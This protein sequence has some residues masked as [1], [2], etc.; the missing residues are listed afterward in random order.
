MLLKSFFR[1]WRFPFFVATLLSVLFF[2]CVVNRA[3]VELDISVSKTTWVKIYWAE[4]GQPFSEKRM[5][6][7]RAR[8]EHNQYSFYLT[9]L[10]KIATLRIDTHQYEGEAVVKRIIIRQKGLQ[11]LYFEGEKEFSLLSPVF[12]VAKSS[13][14]PGGFVVDSTGEDPQFTYQVNLKR[15]SPYYLQAAVCI[16][17]IFLAVFTFFFLTENIRQESAYVPLL[18]AAVCILVMVMA[19]ISDNNSHPDEYV[20][21]KAAKYYTDNW[22]PPAADDPAIRDTYSVYGASRLNNFEVAYFFLGKFVRLLEPFNLS[23]YLKARLFNVML[24]AIMVLSLLRFTELRLLA[25][26][27]LFSPQLW[28]VFSYCNSDAFA[29]FITFFISWQVALPRSMFNQWLR[30]EDRNHPI[31]KIIIFAT[32]CAMLFLLKKNYYFFIIFLAGYFVWQ[33]IVLRRQISLKSFYRRLTLVIVVGLCLAGVRVGISHYVNDFDR[34]AVLV[35]QQEERATPLY[36]A[37]TPLEEKHISLYRRARGQSLEDFVS[38][39]RWFAKSFRS[40]FGVYSYFSISA[41]TFYYTAVR[42]V[43]ITFL[44]YGTL[45]VLIRGGIAGNVLLAYWLCCSAALIGASLY[46]SWTADFQAQGR[47]LFPVIPMLGVVMYHIRSCLP[48]PGFRLLTLSMF[49]LSVYS[50]IFVALLHI[51]KLSHVLN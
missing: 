32:G 38:S 14:L 45:F 50:F 34:D 5:A 3:V 1:Q 15:G 51:S 31:V 20:H 29:L 27:F 46:H 2:Y 17:V 7:V 30:G 18:F 28:Y 24:L 8:P 9:D 43:G 48:S 37:S 6:G 21:L 35:E 36:K 13:W 22:V 40:A 26:P 49:T 16:L 47:Y 39:D 41:S 4:E 19:A 42:W 25:I 33:S 10:R 12:Q 11:P 23:T 44:L